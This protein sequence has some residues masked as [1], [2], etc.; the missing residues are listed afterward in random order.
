V[1]APDSIHTLATCRVINTPV[2]AKLDH[3]ACTLT[4]TR[5]IVEDLTKGN[6]KLG[7]C[8]SIHDPTSS[9]GKVRGKQPTLS[10][11]QENTS[12]HST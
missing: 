5:D 12:L 11:A 6:N 9:F 1:N 7:R 10:A 2:V 3:L 8:G 4:D